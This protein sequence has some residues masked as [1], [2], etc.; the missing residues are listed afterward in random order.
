[1]R[2]INRQPGSGTRFLLDLMLQQAKLDPAAI[3]GYEQ[4]EFTHAAVAAFVASGMADAGFGVEVPAREFKLEFLPTHRER[5]FFVCHERNL[6]SA[7]MR[8]LIELLRSSSMQAAIDALPGYQ[9][10]DSGTVMALDAMFPAL[11][12]RPASR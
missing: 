12:G 10:D 3:H 11:G 1:V 8:R 4:C 9:A 6:A 5:Y 2:F 7:D